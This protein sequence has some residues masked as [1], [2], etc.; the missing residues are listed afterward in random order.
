MEATSAERRVHHAHAGARPRAPARDAAR[1]SWRLP[2]GERLAFT[3]GQFISCALP[4]R[5][6]SAARAGLLAGV[7]SGR[8]RARDLRRPRGP[9]GPGRRVPLRVVARRRRSRFTGPF[10]SFALA[11]PP[12]VPLVFVGEGTGI[13]PHPSDGAARARARRNAP[14]HGAAGR[15]LRPRAPL[16]RRARGIWR[17]RHPRLDWEPVLL[18]TEAELGPIAA[19][20]ELVLERFVRDDADRS[21]RFWICGV[22]R[23][24]GASSRRACGAAGYERRAVRAEQW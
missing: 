1:S 12:P 16:S 4:G 10:G 15:A 14:D 17:R 6:G 13:A 19:L 8:L 22:E 2:P 11:D 3:P 7:E 18:A 24:G 20:E 5:P 21:R 9:A 23:D